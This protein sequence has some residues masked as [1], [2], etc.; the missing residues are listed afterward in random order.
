[1]QDQ[2]EWV[3]RHVD[4]REL[5]SFERKDPVLSDP[6]DEFSHLRRA[7]VDLATRRLCS[8]RKDPRHPKDRPTDGNSTVR[9]DRKWTTLEQ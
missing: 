7:R 2:E 4:S 5:V 6:R 1:M 3:R 9:F 8:R